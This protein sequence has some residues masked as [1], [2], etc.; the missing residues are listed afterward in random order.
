M[1]LNKLEKIQSDAAECA[2][3]RDLA[4]DD[5]A[6]E[7]LDRVVNR[8]NEIAESASAE[9]SPQRLPAQHH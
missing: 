1:Y 9:A 7:A 2:R 6:R 8:L 5:V 3:V 4:T